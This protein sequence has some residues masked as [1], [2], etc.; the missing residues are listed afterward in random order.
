MRGGLVSPWSQ[1]CMCVNCVP[2]CVNV[3]QLQN[4][5]TLLVVSCCYGRACLCGVGSNRQI[6]C[7]GR[8]RIS[9]WKCNRLYKAKIPFSVKY[10]SPPFCDSSALPSGTSHRASATR[11]SV[12]LSKWT[13][14]C[15]YLNLELVLCVVDSS[16]PD[17]NSVCAWIAFTCV[18]MLIKLQN[19]HTLR[20]M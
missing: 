18:S 17:V 13:V 8:R 3:D 5:Y 19:D 16:H 15:P 14:V 9:H 4:H 6:F 2:F 7:R 10:P 12:N 1:Q 20:V 11:W